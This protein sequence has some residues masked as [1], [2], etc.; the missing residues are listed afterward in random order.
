MKNPKKVSFGLKR[1]AT[2]QDCPILIDW[3]A[4]RLVPEGEFAG[5]SEARFYATDRSGYSVSH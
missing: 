2:V 1:F 4:D 5:A 3:V